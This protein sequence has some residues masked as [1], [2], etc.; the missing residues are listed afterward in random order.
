MNMPK[1]NPLIHNIVQ[2]ITARVSRC[3]FNAAMVRWI[4][5]VVLLTASPVFAELPDTST[6]APP[7]GVLILNGHHYGFQRTDAEMNSMISTLRSAYQDLP[8]YVEFLDATRYTSGD[9]IENI[10]QLI[11]SKYIDRPINVL[12]ATD[13]IALDYAI[14]NRAGLAPGAAI[15]FCGISDYTE[16]VLYGAAR[17][18]GVLK[19]SAILLTLDTARELLPAYTNVFVVHDFTSDGLIF[20]KK[21]RQ[22][23]SAFQTKMHFTLPDNKPIETLCSKLS[24]LPPNTLVFLGNY[25]ADSDGRVFDD[26]TVSRLLLQCTDAP[27]L[28]VDETRLANGIVGGYLSSASKLGTIAAEQIIQVLNGTPPESMPFEQEEPSAFTINYDALKQFNISQQSLP[29][30]SIIRNR[31][32]TFYEENTT[33]IWSVSMVIIVLTGL[34]IYLVISVHTRRRIAGELFHH[35]NNLE[36]IVRERTEALELANQYKSQFLANISHEMRTPLNAIIGFSEIIIHADSISIAHQQAET[37]LNE[38][39]IMILIIN[40]LLDHA[41]IESGKFELET[42]VFDLHQTIENIGSTFL[43]HAQKKGLE[44]YTIYSNTPQ[45]LVG[46][47]LR[48]RQILVNLVSNAIKFTQTGSVSIAARRITVNDK[49]AKLRFIVQDTGIGIPQNKIKKLFDSFTQVDGSTTRK[50]GGTGLG[51]TIASDLVR[52]MGGQLSVE[53]EPGKGS[54]FWFDIKLPIAHDVDPSQIIELNASSIE[55]A[56]LNLNTNRSVLIVDDYPTNRQV[57]CMHLQSAGY[58]VRLANNGQEALTICSEERFDLILMDIQMPVMDGYEAS[59]QIR[60][61]GTL[62][63]TTPIVALSAHGIVH[64][65]KQCEAVGINDIITKPVR[66]NALLQKVDKWASACADIH[67]AFE[68]KT[69]VAET[70]KHSTAELPIDYDQALK[71]FEYHAELLNPVIKQFCADLLPQLTLIGQYCDDHNFEAIHQDA[72]RIKGG[73]GNLIAMPL[74]RAAMRLDELSKQAAP[75]AD[76]IREQLLLVELEAEKLIAFMDRK[77][78]MLA[79]NSAE[80]MTDVPG[81]STHE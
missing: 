54:T 48:L 77:S 4:L 35:K 72:H 25:N 20:R 66:R 8:V 64:I 63:T 55:L 43:Q 76:T 41:K 23:I 33:L 18:T 57:A 15:V 22:T 52:M 21:I 1:Y 70:Q 75:N 45:L 81:T 11:R 3:F 67:P 80:V 6:D 73:A 58:E 49:T 61:G 71:E 59:R 50:Y 16:D 27:I 13:N 2:I 60:K 30:N 17:I 42:E 47:A 19:E 10:T 29:P 74:Y 56:D 51:T 65:Q 31:P 36:G 5:M 79:Q 34:I 39:E 38:S 37:I 68:N 46:D 24:D 78:I 26:A 62:N 9:Y 12:A 69:E 28:V 44:F 7:P 53:S 32:V 40:Q 14:N